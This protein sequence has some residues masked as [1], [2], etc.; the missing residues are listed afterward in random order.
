MENDELS[1]EEQHIA[2]DRSPIQPSIKI[3]TKRSVH[4][5]WL[6]DGVCSANEWKDIQLGLIDYF[7]G[8]SVI[9]NPARL[10]RLP[11]FN[12]VSYN[13]EIDDYQYK[14]VEITHFEPEIRF[15]LE[16]M[17]QAFPKPKV[18]ETEIKLT[19]N[20]SFEKS[21]FKVDVEKDVLPKLKKVSVNGDGWMACCP[22]HN[23]TN[24]SL[25]VK[26]D[27]NEMLLFCHSG[28]SFVQIVQKL[29]LSKNERTKSNDL[30]IVKPA[31]EWMEE[32]S[33]KP[34]PKMLFGELWFEGEICI[35]FSDSNAGKSALAVQIADSI[36]KGESVK[37]FVLE[38]EKQKILYLDFEL[39]DRQFTTRYSEPNLGRYINNYKFDKDF[40]RLELNR[41][42]DLGND[43]RDFENSLISAIE[44][45][46]KK[47]DVRI[48]IIDNLTYLKSDTERAKDALPL[49]KRLKAI[50]EKHNVSFLV[51]A[52]T[53]K[54]YS[55]QPLTQND[56]QGSKMLSNFADSIFAIGKSEKDENLRYLKQLK[57]R[58]T[59][60]V[61][62]SNNVCVFELHKLT[63]FLHFS[64]LESGYESE[65]IREVNGK[66]RSEERQTAKEL[67][68]QGKTQREIKEIM[69]I[70]LGKVNE[71]IKEANAEL[72][73]SKKG[74]RSL[75]ET[76]GMNVVNNDGDMSLD[77]E[78]E[79]QTELKI[80]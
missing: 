68:S 64:F 39:N 3:E 19:A 9:K 71:L 76:N 72:P 70:S 43:E 1:L 42:I 38:V 41:D 21:K 37:P 65:H 28:C 34:I 20:E 13:T 22:A 24:P 51:L 69:S 5:Y 78:T 45:K 10:M 57:Q 75:L 14:M 44:T 55:L 31:N 56:L 47:E 25:S 6:I 4:A 23:D 18:L 8:D 29:G 54:R 48:I 66:N 26:Q 60:N 52:H 27:E 73:D 11:N 30:F 7:D 16:E 17:Q 79:K 67:E 32:A 36:T 58:N 63:N 77:C 46:I 49:M 80:E 15:T 12:H 53:P 61:Y 35:L 40:L 59:E 33:K 62:G 2:L 50:K 74:V